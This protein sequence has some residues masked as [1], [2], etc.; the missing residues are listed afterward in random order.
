LERS[1]SEAGVGAMRSPG[2][3]RTMASA[4]PSR[5]SMLSSSLATVGAAAPGCAT[6]R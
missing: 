5:R 6:F 4:S 2:V 1:G 3:Q